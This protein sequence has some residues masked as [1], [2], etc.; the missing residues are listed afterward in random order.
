MRIRS[1]LPLLLLLVATAAEAQFRTPTQTACTV[2]CPAGPQGPPG[3]E[4]PRGPRGDMGVQ[5]SRGRDGR[6][7]KDATQCPAKNYR[8]FDL[9]SHAVPFPV[10]AVVKLGCDVRIIAYNP[11]L[12][13]AVLV[14]P[15]TGLGEV[16]FEFTADLLADERGPITFDAVESLDRLWLLWSHKGG[17]WLHRWPGGE[18]VD[19]KNVRLPDPRTGVFEPVFR[20]REDLD[21]PFGQ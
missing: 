20:W 3:P 9:G 6:D 16:I 13:A 19:L 11:A 1:I 17:H 14:D 18:T 5:G 10:K 4:G 2:E 8:P 7:G 21:R 15:A 12:R